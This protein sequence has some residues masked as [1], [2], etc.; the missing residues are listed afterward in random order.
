M[1]DH[2]PDA[3]ST[4][5]KRETKNGRFFGYFLSIIPNLLAR[6]SRFLLDN[7]LINANMKTIPGCWMLTCLL[8]GGALPLL[9]QADYGQ[10]GYGSFSVTTLEGETLQVGDGYTLSVI[11]SWDLKTEQVV[12]EIPALNQ[13]VEAFEGHQVQFIAVTRNKAEDVQAYLKTHPFAYAQVAGKEGKRVSK[14][15]KNGGLV[16]TYPLHL[17]LDK[18]GKLL[19]SAAGSCSTVHGLLAEA[20][21]P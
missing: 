12:G 16:R 11:C 3:P 5:L 19:Q 15:L 20:L 2:V 4:F 7:Y 10:A 8:L 21:K 17:V 14:L 6:S 13:L 18:Q 1:E 9:A